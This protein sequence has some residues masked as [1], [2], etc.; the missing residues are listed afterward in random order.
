VIDK[1]E[2]K[3]HIAKR[4]SRP[5]VRIIPE[6]LGGGRLPRKDLTEAVEQ[7]SKEARLGYSWSDNR[8]LT[9]RSTRR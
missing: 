4:M 5:M 3:P 8:R 7:R 1:K 2:G 9:R 6:A